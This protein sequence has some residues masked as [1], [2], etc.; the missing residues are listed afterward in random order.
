MYEQYK[1]LAAQESSV[2][3][4]GRLVEYKYYNMDQVIADALNK[5]D[6]EI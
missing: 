2:I 1:A 4:G 5:C 6:E 3:F